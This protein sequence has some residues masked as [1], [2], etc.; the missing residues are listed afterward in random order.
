VAQ[1][2]PSVIPVMCCDAPN[3]GR[4]AYADGK[5]IK[6]EADTTLVALDA[7]NGQQLWKTRTGDP[8]KGEVGDRV[9][10]VVDDKVLVGV[11]G[12]E[13][14][15]RDYVASL[16]VKTGKQLW[17]AYSKG[18][19]EDILFNPETTLAEGKPVGKD[20]SLKTWTGDQWSMSSGKQLSKSVFDP[21]LKLMYY[22]ASEATPFQPQV[23]EQSSARTIFAR[24][25]NT[26][27]AKW[28]YQL[29]LA[30]DGEGGGNAELTLG[31]KQIN[32]EKRKVV[33]YLD[34]SGHLFTLDRAKGEL[35][36]SIK[37]KSSTP[38]EKPGNLKP[39]QNDPSELR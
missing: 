2:D 16:D 10:Y 23:R 13:F 6:Y 38:A 8:H 33:D 17:R 1:L 20:S 18:P 35:L 39:W 19:D 22:A 37:I 28:I 31:E 29:P 3:I 14:G 7:K 26:G 15:A 5:V 25:L 32:G 12:R 36:E 27:E 34:A 11:S 9:P 24:D 4:L 30:E 21:E